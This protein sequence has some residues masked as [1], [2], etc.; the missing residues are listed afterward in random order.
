[1]RISRLS[2]VVDAPFEGEM[3]ILNS[4]GQEIKKV[5]LNGIYLLLLRDN[6][7]NVYTDR[8]IIRR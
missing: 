8:V 4:A 6:I 1:L 5:I 3:I 7:G 2:T